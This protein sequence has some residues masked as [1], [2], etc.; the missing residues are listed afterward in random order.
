[1]GRRR[2]G[3]G[4][5]DVQASVSKRLP[6][7]KYRLQAKPR[8]IRSGPPRATCGGTRGSCAEALQ[9]I[10]SLLDVPGWTRPHAA[11]AYDF[12]GGRLRTK[13][14]AHTLACVA[15]CVMRAAVSTTKKRGF[16]DI[17]MSVLHLAAAAARPR[18]RNGLRC[19]ELLFWVTSKRP[20]Q[21]GFLYAK[22]AFACRECGR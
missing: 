9:E 14:H 5:R 15:R 18:V 8:T 12:G 21:G 22:T 4:A 17:A 1:M 11:G 2:A 10:E 19:S 20:E 7:Q 16:F 6:R 13:F 3:R